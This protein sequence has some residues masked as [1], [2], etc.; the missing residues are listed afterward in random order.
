[1]VHR[2]AHGM[3]GKDLPRTVR[4]P[5]IGHLIP[6]AF[7]QLEHRHGCC[8]HHTNMNTMATKRTTTKSKGTTKKEQ[9]QRHTLRW[10][11][12]DRRR[13]VSSLNT[14]L[15]N[16]QV[17]YQKLRNYHWNVT[18]GDFFDIHEDL[19]QQYGEAQLNIDLI[20]E[21]VRVFRERPLSTFSEYLKASTLKEDP[22]TP[23]SSKM[24]QNLLADYVTLVDRMC[25]TVDL[26]MELSDSGTE[27]MVKGF[28]E[29]V[30]KHHWMLTAFTK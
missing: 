20:A 13:I 30:E 6:L 4:I 7:T 24:M 15:A 28:I 2:A 18:G 25:E 11:A 21:R 19:E 29:Q 5:H 27:R 8:W 26:A 3:L 12:E 9:G 1:M 17:H 22:G 10:S 14:L 23:A 16:Y